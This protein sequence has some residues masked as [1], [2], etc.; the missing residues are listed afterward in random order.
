MGWKK[1]IFCRE[2]LE[3]GLEALRILGFRFWDLDW[4]VLV[5]F[6]EILGLSRILL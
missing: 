5:G 6:G 3:L 1:G 4:W 2:M